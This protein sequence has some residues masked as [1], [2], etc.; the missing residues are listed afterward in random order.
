VAKYVQGNVVMGA[1]YLPNIANYADLH[2][3]PVRK[4]YITIEVLDKNNDTIETVQGLSTGGSLSVSGD[5]LIKR[6]GSLS[7]VLFDSLLPKRG[8]LLW[9]TNKIRVYAGIENNMSADGDLTN[10]CLG[11]F[12]ITEPS[13]DISRDSRS[14]SISLQ[15]N[16]MRWEEE[17]LENK[18]VFDAGTPLYTAVTSLMNLYGEWNIDIEFTDLKIPYTLEFNEGESVLDIITKLRDLY[19]D[20]ECY[21]DID[22]TF[23]FKHVD[24]QLEGGEPVAWTF[25]KE[26]DLITTF[27]ESFSYKGVKN[28]CVVIG[29]MDSKGVTPRSEANIIDENSQFHRN[30]LG[31]KTIVVVDTTLGDVLQCDARARYELYK[32]STFQEKLEI[33]TLPIYYLDT[34]NVIEVR[35]LATKEMEKYVIDSISI[36]LGIEDEIGLS[37]HK[38]YYNQFE[39]IGGSLGDYQAIADTVINGIQNLGWL[40]LSEK[41]VKDYFGLEGD[42]SDLIVRFEY[43]GLHGVTAYV[44]AFLDESRQTL[45]VDLADFESTG[46]NGD[47]GNGKEEYS[48]RILGHEMV[49]A[50]M[51]N[52]LTIDKTKDMPEWFKEGMAELIHGADER[53]KAI[54]VKDGKVDNTL[55][56]SLVNRCVELLNGASFKSENMDYGAGYVISGFI[57][58]NLTSGKTMK[59]FMY[60]IKMSNKSGDEAVK[61]AIVNTMPFTTYEQFVANFTQNGFNHV[62]INLTLNPTGDEVDTGS[63]AGTDHRGSVPL[64]AE[65]IFDNSKATQGVSAIGFKVGFVRP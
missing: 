64:N 53:L 15:D 37:C 31:T 56:T 24:I 9:M 2:L 1:K 25:D 29:Q 48:D 13:I 55:V 45:T 23:V 54:I 32:A 63:I 34:G 28:R 10:F 33:N 7:F 47:T 49:H 4:L 8:S 35:N 19:M 51:N 40:S 44:T 39:T 50:I 14:I 20:W 27:K 42:G 43:E 36:G 26:T 16:M 12:F 30:E 46:E 11:T 41:R 22:G 3:Q 60:S 5:S 57:D 21:Y 17:Y 59:D 62:K 18:L 6:T 61:E 58:M 52:A 38:V 65:D